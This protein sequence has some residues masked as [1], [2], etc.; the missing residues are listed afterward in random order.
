ME[1]PE[2]EPAR[3]S[4]NFFLLNELKGILKNKENWTERNPKWKKIYHE[5]N[6]DIDFMQRN[7]KNLHKLEFGNVCNYW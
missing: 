3:F 7:F 5:K 1:L 4:A 2:M 6:P